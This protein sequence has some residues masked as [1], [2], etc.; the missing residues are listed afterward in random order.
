MKTREKLKPQIVPTLLSSKTLVWSVVLTFVFLGGLMLYFAVLGAKDAQRRLNQPVSTSVMNN[1]LQVDEPSGW[2]HFARSADNIRLYRGEP[3]TLPMI[4]IETARNGANAYQALDLN[5]GLLVRRVAESLAAERIAE[6]VFDVADTTNSVPMVTLG[7]AEVA[8]VKAGVYAQRF[9]FMSG[10]VIGH[11]LQF[12]LGERSY[13][14][15]GIAKRNDAEGLDAIEDFIRRPQSSLVLPEPYEDIERPVIDSSQLTAEG[16][17]KVLSEVDR[18]VAMWRLFAERAKT[19]PAAAM[20][21]AL[22][23]F[24]E[25]VRLLSSIRQES[26]LVNGVDFIRYRELSDERKEKLDEWFVLLDK[27]RSMKDDEAAKRQAK[28]ISEHATLKGEGPFASRARDIYNEI[29]AVEGAR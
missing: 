7:G 27:F 16:N 23:H 3:E 5:R 4:R 1:A 12:Y 29:L 13:L 18:E 14:I 8:S 2:R 25:A 21:P 9:V 28:Y 6:S 17:R 19:E 22:A 24:R 10:E 15:W 11:G 26:V 20:V